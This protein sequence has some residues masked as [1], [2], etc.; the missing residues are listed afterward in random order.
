M[1]G[2]ASVRRE[3]HGA[4]PLLREEQVQVVQRERIGGPGPGRGRRVGQRRLVH[5]RHPVAGRRVEPEGAAL[6][7]DLDEFP[8]P[9]HAPAHPEVVAVQ[10]RVGREPVGRPPPRPHRP[11]RHAGTG[12][13]D[14]VG[15]RVVTGGLRGEVQ[16]GCELRGRHLRAP[17]DRL[18]LQEDLAPDAT[19][20]VFVG[21]V[22]A[23]RRTVGGH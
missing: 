21:E 3:G 11:P 14:P 2:P 10:A 8:A 23:Q 19:G 13:R 18:G 12:R 20:P 5:V 6:V 22:V 4:L 15:V 17:E 9:V 7:G 1:P 16:P